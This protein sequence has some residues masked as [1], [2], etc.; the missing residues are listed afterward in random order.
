MYYECSQKIALGG[1]STSVLPNLGQRASTA[2]VKCTKSE[3]YLISFN[4]TL[5]LVVQIEVSCV[6]FRVYRSFFLPYTQFKDSS[7]QCTTHTVFEVYSVQVHVLVS[8]VQV[9]SVQVSSVQVSSVHES[10]VHVSS[11]Y[12]S[13]VH[14]SRVHVS[15][16]HGS[17]TTLL[18]LWRADSPIIRDK[19][20]ISLSIYQKEFKE[21]T[22]VKL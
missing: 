22:T 1:D 9:S 16:V 19:T 7:V 14:V 10:S 15:R 17:S 5:F 3:K 6:Q 8:S 4:L 12:V 2:V 13:S 21:I 18:V 20:D 11:V